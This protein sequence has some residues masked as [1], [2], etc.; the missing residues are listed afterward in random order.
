MTVCSTPLAVY[1]GCQIFSKLENR[2]GSYWT[3]TIESGQSNVKVH[4]IHD[5]RSGFSNGL[6]SRDPRR[7]RK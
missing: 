4:Y 6:K 3:R 7:L 1:D 2:E 5:L